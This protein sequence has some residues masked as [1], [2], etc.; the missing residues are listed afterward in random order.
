MSLKMEDFAVESCMPF[1]L[2]TRQTYSGF[3]LRLRPFPQPV[4]KHFVFPLNIT[5]KTKVHLR[6]RW[7]INFSK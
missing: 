1:Q 6:G 5:G 4:V 3:L 2:S 7:C